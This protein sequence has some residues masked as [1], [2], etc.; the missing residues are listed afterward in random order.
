VIISALRILAPKPL[1]VWQ[2]RKVLPLGSLI[3][4]TSWYL[5]STR[6]APL[7]S[8]IHAIPV[9]SSHKESLG[10]KTLDAFCLTLSSA[11]S[12]INPQLQCTITEEVAP[13]EP[14]PQ[15]LARNVWKK[16]CVSLASSF[17]YIG[18]NLTS[19]HYSYECKAVVQERP[20]VS[21]PSRTQQLFNPRLVPKL[22][23]DAPKDLLR[24]YVCFR[25]LS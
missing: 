4:M 6:H 23:S 5:T 13:R 8:D 14:Q 1:S 10:L 19:R 24:K 20:Y 17:A 18:T 7:N 3:A 25:N 15:Q 16:I 2:L 22:T 11:S 21:R 12:P 9:I